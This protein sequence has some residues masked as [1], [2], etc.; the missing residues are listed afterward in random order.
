MK[1]LFHLTFFFHFGRMAILQEYQRKGYGSIL[2]KE[3]IEYIKLKKEGKIISIH[4][5][6]DK[7]DFYK[8]LGFEIVSD[9]F[10]ECG[11]EHYIM[12]LNF[13]NSNNKNYRNYQCYKDNYC[14]NHIAN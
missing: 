7:S 5:Q 3:I 9:L 10:L 13:C 4:S 2:V 8:K 1:R 14:N 12:N 6:A 11:I